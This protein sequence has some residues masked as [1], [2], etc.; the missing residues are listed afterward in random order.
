VNV[1]YQCI[2]AVHACPAS[3]T[4]RAA[5][6]VVVAGAVAGSDAS[7]PA[8]ATYSDTGAPRS[9]TCTGGGSSHF[10]DV[11]PTD[12]HCRHVNYLWARGMID[13]YGDGT[14]KPAQNVTR[15]QMAKFITTGFGLSLYQ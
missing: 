4:S 14:F 3:N 8:S 12:A 5:M 7:V 10:P 1:A 13:G 15:G 9:Y 6:A 11:A 2:D